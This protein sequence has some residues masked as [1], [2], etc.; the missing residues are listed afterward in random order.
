MASTDAYSA[1]RAPNKSTPLTASAIRDMHLQV[2]RWA[3]HFQIINRVIQLTFIL[4]VNHLIGGKSS[5]K[6]LFHKHA[7]FWLIMLGAN[8][9]VPVSALDT[10]PYD[11]SLSCGR[12]IPSIKGVV[13][14]AKPSGYREMEA[15]S[16]ATYWVLVPEN[17][18]SYIWVPVS[19]ESLV[20]NQAHS[21]CLSR[22]T[23][24][25][26]SAVPNHALCIAQEINLV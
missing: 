24:T 6:M 12:S 21:L 8:Q 26:R 5:P 16:D 2:L 3:E 10:K 20:V 13:V 15:T 14:S 22:S 7:M 23:A 4:V 11:W 19:L 9:N 25:I 18:F 1:N 17:L